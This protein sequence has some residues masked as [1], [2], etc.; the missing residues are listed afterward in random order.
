MENTIKAYLERIQEFK[1]CKQGYA[2]LETQLSPQQAWDA[3][4]EPRWMLWLIGMVLKEPDSPQRRA[5]YEAA[6][7]KD[8][9]SLKIK[10]SACQHI[11]TLYPEIPAL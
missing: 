4:A 10:E 1:C 11:R 7:G 8:G 6:Y 2:W 3:C 5:L 9:T